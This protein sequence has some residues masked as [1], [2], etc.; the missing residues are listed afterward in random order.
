VRKKEET[1][2]GAERRTAVDEREERGGEHS[3]GAVG[4]KLDLEKEH[5]KNE[6]CITEA[7]KRKTI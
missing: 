7:E 5:R 2:K 1:R 6:N 3:T 4:S